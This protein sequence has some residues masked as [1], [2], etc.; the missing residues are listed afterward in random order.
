MLTSVTAAAT[1]HDKPLVMLPYL[2][3]LA[4]TLNSFRQIK[5]ATKH[6]SNLSF[7]E[8]L[9]L[10][11]IVVVI[12]AVVVVFVLGALAQIISERNQPSPR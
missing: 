5:T 12:V 7:L 9:S 6:N 8:R 10:V 2:P 4:T 11:V 3:L 1:L